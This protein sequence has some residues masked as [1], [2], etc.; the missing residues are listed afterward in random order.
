[1]TTLPIGD[2]AR[3]IL[4]AVAQMLQ[5]PGTL[6][7]LTVVFWFVYMQAARSAA[8]EQY[9][10]GIVRVSVRRQALQAL[11]MGLLGGAIAT[12]L[13]VGLGIAFDI[14]LWIWWPVL[15]LTALVLAMVQPR[16]MCFAYAGGLISL[17]ALVLGT[18]TVD[19]PVLMAL[20]AALHLVEAVLVW[21]TGHVSPTPLYIKQ[22]DGRVVGGFAL[23]KAWPLPFI[24]VVG[25][26]VAREV[27]AGS[28][29]VPMPDWWPLFRP[30]VEVPPGHELAFQL[31]PVVA[32]LGYGD[33]T[34]TRDPKEKARHSAGGLVLFSLVLLALALGARR[35]PLL[36]WAAAVFAPVGHDLLIQWG[37]W[38][39]RGE[40]VFVNR[41]GVM[42]LDVVPD[43]PAA[44]MGLRSGD[45]I[46][47]FNGQ[48]VP[49][50]QALQAAMEPWCVDIELEVESRLPG[51][52]RRRR[53]V[54]YPGK[55]PPLG[56][57]PAPDPDE[58]RYVTLQYT[59]PLQ[60]L[61]R[62]VRQWMAGRRSL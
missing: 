4:Q 33:F 56:I 62:R 51:A 17:V 29:G 30:A 36:A 2:L 23:Q 15:F 52:W 28:E 47:S 6:I 20:V 27:L 39:E 25:F 16:F 44:R 26:I 50:R 21:L 58:P 35:W 9:M 61:W 40:P 1:M 57:V 53:I 18:P 59:G 11:G 45:V 49:D 7:L 5:S 32:G 41:D 48:P 10:F 55:V 3:L 19:V 14:N 22:P 38:R 46:L 13:F 60:R 37:R 24:A 43:S 8:F 34:V 12:A 31:I 42:V 54:R